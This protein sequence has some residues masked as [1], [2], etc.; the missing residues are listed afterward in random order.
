MKSKNLQ[1]WWIIFSDRFSRLISFHLRRMFSSFMKIV[2]LYDELDSNCSKH[3]LN[4]FL[5]KVV[6]RSNLIANNK[7]TRCSFPWHKSYTSFNE[8]KRRSHVYIYRD[9][10][11]LHLQRHHTFHLS[12]WMLRQKDQHRLFQSAWRTS[13]TL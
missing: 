10:T 1:N 4:N 2:S 13:L 11:R 9:I 12:P 8:S 7:R 6:Q 5:H 3:Q